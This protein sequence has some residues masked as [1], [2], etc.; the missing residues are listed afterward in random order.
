MPCA[1]QATRR[2]RTSCKARFAASRGHARAVFPPR[3]SPIRYS[4]FQRTASS[5]PEGREPSIVSARPAGSAAVRKPLRGSFGFSILWDVWDVWDIWDI[6]D[7]W[8]K[9]DLAAYC[10]S[11]SVCTTIPGVLHSGNRGTGTIFAPF[12]PFLSGADLR[13]HSHQK[14]LPVPDFLASN[15]QSFVS[16]N[17]GQAAIFRLRNRLNESLMT[18][19]DASP[20]VFTAPLIWLRLLSRVYDSPCQSV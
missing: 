8:D 15:H 2:N 9:R 13:Y 16:E 6:C 18:E 11:V 14:W 17:W 12:L 7:V 4:F 10:M 20:P 1:C 19:N 3:V 5:T